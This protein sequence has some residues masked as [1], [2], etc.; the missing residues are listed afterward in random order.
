MEDIR[1]SSTYSAVQV[2]KAD[3]QSKHYSTAAQQ[4]ANTPGPVRTHQDGEAWLVK[5]VTPS[6]T[7][8]CHY[9]IANSR[10]LDDF[11]PLTRKYPE[12]AVIIIIITWACSMGRTTEWEACN[13]L[14]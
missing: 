5:A 12:V 11:Q 4:L 9:S 3:M 7:H 2:G 6:R 13:R 10:D 1:L 8:C 14:T